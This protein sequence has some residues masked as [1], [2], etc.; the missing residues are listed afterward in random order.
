M[1]RGVPTKCV[2]HEGRE[3]ETL[4]DMCSYHDLPLS[5]YYSRKKLGWSIERI[6]TEPCT[7]IK[8]NSNIF[9]TLF[10]RFESQNELIKATGLR[11][12]IL[13]ERL[14]NGVEVDV[15]ILVGN[16]TNVSLKFIGM[17][18]KAYYKIHLE[19]SKIMTT[20]EVIEF[21]RPDLLEKYDEMNPHGIYRPH[22]SRR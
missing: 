17:N 6:L 5:R 12:E 15:C 13:K 21:Y 4:L 3:F 1:P 7:P 2:D 20:R 14:Y 22:N 16:Q 9:E 19:G 8:K 10:G 18:R 11:K